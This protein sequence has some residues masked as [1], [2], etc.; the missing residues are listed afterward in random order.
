[1]VLHLDER[2]LLPPESFIDKFSYFFPLPQGV[3]MYI[4]VKHDHPD[5]GHQFL[6]VS[7]FKIYAAGFSEDLRFIVKAVLLKFLFEL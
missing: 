4:S 5:Y 6:K 3:F 2:P 1:M 7:Y